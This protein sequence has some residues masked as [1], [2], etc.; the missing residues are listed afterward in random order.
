MNTGNTQRIIRGMI[1]LVFKDDDE[2]TADE[3][4]EKRQ[5]LEDWKKKEKRNKEL[6]TAYEELNKQ[7]LV[8][9]VKLPIDLVGAEQS[10]ESTKAAKT[11]TD[12]Q[13]EEYLKN[14][15][16]ASLERLKGRFGIR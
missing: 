15:F 13:Y 4:L 14:G 2:L 16:D 3:L 5:K 9:R 8:G 10:D 7:Y 12:E 1:Q 6:T 11:G